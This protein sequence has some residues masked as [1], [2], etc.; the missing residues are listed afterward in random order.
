MEPIGVLKLRKPLL[1]NGEHVKQ[2]PYDFEALTVEDITEA[3]RWRYEDQGM[4][5]L[6]PGID[7]A[8]QLN[9]FARAV[10][11][12]TTEIGKEDLERMGAK[13]GMRAAALARDFFTAAETG[14]D[15]TEEETPQ[16]GETL[17]MAAAPIGY[18][19][20]EEQTDPE[21]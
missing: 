11:K 16:P 19:T 3:D 18:R 14:E 1:V 6:F 12:A 15:E 7:R 10:E 9:L 21:D 2:V 8:T 20:D 4:P 5:A 17:E 13:D